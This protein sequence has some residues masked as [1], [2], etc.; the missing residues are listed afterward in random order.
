[1]WGFLT[2]YPPQLTFWK[3]FLCFYKVKSTYRRYSLYYVY[4]STSL[5]CLDNVVFGCLLSLWWPKN[6]IFRSIRHCI[7]PKNVKEQLRTEYKDWRRNWKKKVRTFLK[8]LKGWKW[9]R[10]ITRG[11][12]PQSTNSCQVGIFFNCSTFPKA[13]L[14]ANFG[15]LL[16]SFW[17]CFMLSSIQESLTPKSLWYNFLFHPL[18]ILK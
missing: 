13:A 9:M 18:F 11:C 14:E 5:P 15:L 4:L 10:S 7:R 3:N 6:N 17:C 16:S 8:W 1:M 2:T 12:R